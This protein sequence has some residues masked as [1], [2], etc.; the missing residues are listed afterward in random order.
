MAT[1]PIREKFLLFRLLP[2]FILF[3]AFVQE[4][5]I[6]GYV[7]EIPHN[8]LTATLEVCTV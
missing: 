6:D 2:N 5:A 4:V 8:D 1:L 3:C 7:I